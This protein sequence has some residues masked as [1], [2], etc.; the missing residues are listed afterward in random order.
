MDTTEEILTTKPTDINSLLGAAISLALLIWALK[1]WIGDLPIWVFVFP[2]ALVGICLV[3][4]VAD[5]IRL[6]REYKG[7]ERELDIL[8]LKIKAWDDA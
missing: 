3:C 8:I 4:I 5:I 6:R 1:V 2:Y 7:L